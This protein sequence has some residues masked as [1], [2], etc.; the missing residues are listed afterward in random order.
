MDEIFDFFNP[1]KQT[2]KKEVFAGSLANRRT[3]IETVSK[4]KSARYDDH[5]NSSKYAEPYVLANNQR[6]L[7]VSIEIH[8]Q[9]FISILFVVVVTL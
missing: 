8:H 5:G 4:Q 6:L 2:P 3:T 9:H 1:N 7:N